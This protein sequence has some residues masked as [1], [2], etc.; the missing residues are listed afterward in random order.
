VG[1]EDRTIPSPSR[2]HVE[3]VVVEFDQPQA[4][5]RLGV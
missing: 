5:S 2:P 3:H 4:I 1:A